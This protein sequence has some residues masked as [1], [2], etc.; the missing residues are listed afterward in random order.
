MVA[1]SNTR[2]AIRV[3]QGASAIAS[4]IFVSLGY[5]EYTS[6]QLSSGAAIFSTIANYTALLASAY[7][8]IALRWLGLSK[9]AP[10]AL[11]QR[12][13]DGV[14]A[15]ALTLAGIFHASSEAK[16]DCTSQNMLFST[17][18]GRNLF[19]CGSMTWGIV[20]TFVT[21]G[22][23]FF[24]AAFS[25][26]RDS[27]ASTETA[28]TSL[29]AQEEPSVAMDYAH[30]VTPVTKVAAGTTTV[31][32][33]N[34]VNRPALRAIRLGGRAVQ[35]ACSVAALIFTVAGYKHYY[36]GQY[37]SPKATYAILIA[38]T[39]SLYSLW[40]LVAVEHFKLTRRPAL[41]V[42]RV[43]DAVLAFALLIAGV[44]VAT[45]SHIANC[46][47]TNDKF[48]VNH[49]TTLFRCGSMNSGVVFTFI[50]VVTYLVTIASTYMS[51][52]VEENGRETTLA[53]DDIQA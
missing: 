47:E 10:R 31:S 30:V 1:I 35:F 20:L 34:T 28:T 13:F 27:A 14:I 16:K 38:Y 21:A 39:C 37:L 8:V 9:T 46:D 42:E 49:G 32:S 36:T 53:D 18:H 2:T 40:H 17:Y 41:K 15:V 48:A 33:V 3:V 24:T 52:A 22:L 12:G 23:F 44:V 50:A 26:V 51:G 43:G 11:F 5:I 45:S 19:R 6:G 29:S 7:Y 4:M 25:F